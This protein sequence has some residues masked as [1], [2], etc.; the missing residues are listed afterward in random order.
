MYVVFI[1]KVLLILLYVYLTGTCVSPLIVVC[2]C[3]GPSSLWQDGLFSR[4]SSCRS[5][6][7]LEINCSCYDFDGSADSH[8]KKKKG[9]YT[10]FK[11]RGM[12][13]KKRKKKE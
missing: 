6:K 10:A 5:N 4:K 3:V 1:K 7:Q 13:R 9:I 11:G 8:I 12:K 2:N